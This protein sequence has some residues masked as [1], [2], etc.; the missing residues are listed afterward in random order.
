MLDLDEKGGRLWLS[1][2][3]LKFIFFIIITSNT[4][5]TMNKYKI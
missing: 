5:E 3:N 4:S 2:K 1:K